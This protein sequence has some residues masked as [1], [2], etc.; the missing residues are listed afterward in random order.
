M[1][2]CLQGQPQSHKNLLH[3]K[4]TSATTALSTTPK[5]DLLISPTCS[6][7]GRPTLTLR[8]PGFPSEHL[9]NLRAPLMSLRLHSHLPSSRTR[10]T[11]AIISPGLG[12]VPHSPTGPG[13]QQ[14]PQGLRPCGV[15]STRR[16]PHPR[17]RRWKWAGHQARRESEVEGAGA[18]F[19]H[20][21]WTWNQVREKK[22]WVCVDSF[23]SP[24]VDLYL[25]ML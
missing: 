12:R 23:L 20:R 10:S 19:C 15:S 7:P 14:C 5:M 1:I 25:H 9:I 21:S 17:G 11:S 22:I 8:L 4:S 16:N 13:P 18:A 6:Q 24:W 3:L 2:V